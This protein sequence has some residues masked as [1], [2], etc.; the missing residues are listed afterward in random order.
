MINHHKPS[1]VNLIAHYFKSQTF[2]SSAKVYRHPV[3]ENAF[4]SSVRFS[5]VLTVL[6]LFRSKVQC[7]SRSSRQSLTGN[8]CKIKK[9]KKNLYIFNIQWHR[10]NSSILKWRNVSIVSKYHTKIR[11]KPIMET[12]NS[13]SPHL[14]SGAVMG[15]SGLQQV[16]IAPHHP[17]FSCL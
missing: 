10:I 7:L 15:S 2:I 3:G 12:P 11:Q 6:T 13:A 1:L 4:S 5:K 17:Q 14:A 8:V 9:K 16:F